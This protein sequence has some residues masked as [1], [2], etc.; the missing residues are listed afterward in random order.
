MFGVTLA[1]TMGCSALISSCKCVELQNKVGHNCRV[2]GA[3]WV[4]GGGGI[5]SSVYSHG[6]NGE[7][8]LKENGIAVGYVAKFLQPDWILPVVN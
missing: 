3:G 7:F 4:G 5:F 6:F 1:T 8:C 2:V